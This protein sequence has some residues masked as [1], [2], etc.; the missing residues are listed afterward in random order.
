MTD[1]TTL[2][3]EFLQEK[4]AAKKLAVQTGLLNL[5]DRQGPLVPFMDL[6]GFAQLSLTDI[7][8]LLPSE[9]RLPPLPDLS[10]ILVEVPATDTGGNIP[11][12][13]AGYT[14]ID[15][16][17][18]DRFLKLIEEDLAASRMTSFE[19]EATQIV[20]KL[21]QIKAAKFLQKYPQSVLKLLPPALAKR[22][23]PYLEE[24]M[25]MESN[26]Q[27]RAVDGE[28]VDDFDEVQEQLQNF[29]LLVRR[30]ARVAV[31]EILAAQVEALLGKNLPVGSGGLLLFEH[32]KPS[33]GLVIPSHHHSPRNAVLLRVEQ[34]SVYPVSVK[35]QTY[36]SRRLSADVDKVGNGPNT[37]TR[38][39]S[40]VS[41]E[42]SEMDGQARVGLFLLDNEVVKKELSQVVTSDV[43]DF[44]ISFVQANDVSATQSTDYVATAYP[45]EKLSATLMSLREEIQ[46]QT[47]FDER[48]LS[49]AEIASE[50]QPLIFS[51]DF[52]SIYQQSQ[53]LAFSAVIPSQLREN[54][55][56]LYVNN[57]R[58]TE[59]GQQALQKMSEAQIRNV[60]VA[61][62]FGFLPITNQSFH[63][64][65]HA[66][67]NVPV[68]KSQAP[69][70]VLIRKEI[71]S[72]QY[73]LQTPLAVVQRVT[74]AEP[75]QGEPLL[76]AAPKSV[77]GHS[78][79]KRLEQ[80]RSSTEEDVLN[81]TIFAVLLF[82]EALRNRAEEIERNKVLY[83][84]ADRLLKDIRRRQDALI[85]QQTFLDPDFL[86]EQLTKNL[87][88]ELNSYHSDPSYYDPEDASRHGALRDSHSRDSGG[89]ADSDGVYYPS[90]KSQEQ[91]MSELNDH[92]KQLKEGDLDPNQRIMK[93]LEFYVNNLRGVPESQQGLYKQ[94]GIFV[95]EAWCV[96]FSR[97]VTAA[98]GLRPVS[99]A[100]VSSVFAEFGARINPQGIKEGD[101]AVNGRHVGFVYKV[102]R[103]AS[104]AV[105][106]YDFA[107]GNTVEGGKWTV[108]V[109]KISIGNN[110]YTFFR[111]TGAP[112]TQAP[113]PIIAET[114]GVQ[115]SVFSSSPGMQKK[116]QVAVNTAIGTPT[117]TF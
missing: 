6:I 48:G 116:T 96:N 13:P 105:T 61:D 51:T 66:F 76:K 45:E 98:A 44:G 65:S 49:S 40:E 85:E 107:S 30:R 64:T 8:F 68:K 2:L 3:P 95:G 101:V 56:Q 35:A 36:Y 103:D 16:R 43:S 15:F 50:E 115:G 27:H 57:F 33:P 100:H 112:A 111:H 99:G 26:L 54:V 63:E 78:K 86:S 82:H 28:T 73:W 91:L 90:N 21:G 12:V 42:K 22:L 38:N 97:A 11:R 46:S 117:I 41:I 81:V 89:A 37:Q 84:N 74:N 109:Q 92:L 29:G 32:I 31:L 88:G 102:H 9:L 114:M 93:M 80:E 79:N 4:P 10:E 75:S 77:R 18:R 58:N 19:A 94:Y 47:S 53:V 60:P 83:P 62:S 67:I 52:L 108:G 69:P 20:E 110:P 5:E 24:H 17:D 87:G 23:E 25:D 1:A 14:Q 113:P 59:S 104:G 34:S 7:H 70:D 72:P 39:F 55:R 71:S 106:G